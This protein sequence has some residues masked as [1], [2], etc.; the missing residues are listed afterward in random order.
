MKREE[1][2][3]KI[4]YFNQQ[5]IDINNE[6]SEKILRELITFINEVLD[7]YDKEK[8]KNASLEK[9]IKLM[10]SININDNYICK[11]KIRKI[12]KKYYYIDNTIKEIMK[13][14]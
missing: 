10:K 8:E 3:K 6:K 13:L 11:D 1:I 7:L 14:L 9:E 2:N 5:E 4:D 12:I